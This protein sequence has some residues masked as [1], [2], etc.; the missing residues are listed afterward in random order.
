M[1]RHA[2]WH[3]SFPQLCLRNIATSAAIGTAKV[4]QVQRRTDK[5]VL[6]T[7]QQ[8]GMSGFHPT[9]S[10]VGLV[11]DPASGRDRPEPVIRWRSGV[12]RSRP[13]SANGRPIRHPYSKACR[14]RLIPS[15]PAK[16]GHPRLSGLLQRKTWIAG[17]S[18]AMTALGRGHWSW[19]LGWT[20]SSPPR[21]RL[22]A[23]SPRLTGPNGAAEGGI[24]VGESLTPAQIA[25]G[26]S[27]CG[28]GL[29]W[30]ANGRLNSRASTALSSNS[31][32]TAT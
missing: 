5:S 23:R 6:I 4:A 26:Q 32:G 21:H 11:G 24:A 17:P 27:G 16:A 31:T 10:F 1:L 30:T 3:G 2:S 28:L 12:G 25:P 18:P 19:Y 22:D 13:M 7:P 15:W 20:S 8:R 14:P 9:W 29:T